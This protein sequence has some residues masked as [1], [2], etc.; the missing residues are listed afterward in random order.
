VPAHQH[1]QMRL[2]AHFEAH[3]I[4]AEWERDFVDVRWEHAGQTWIGEVKLTRYLTAAEAFRAALGQ[5][6]VYGATQFSEPLR[7]AMFLDAIPAEPLLSLAERLGVAVIVEMATGRFELR[8]RTE[9]QEFAKLF[10]PR[11]AS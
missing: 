10:P 11:K 5:L 6:L 3:G 7:M 2:R 4:S 9:D 8:S 1:Y